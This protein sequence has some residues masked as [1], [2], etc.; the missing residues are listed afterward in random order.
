MSF[1]ISR[2]LS[3]DVI[4]KFTVSACLSFQSHFKVVLLAACSFRSTLIDHWNHSFR[5]STPLSHL[6][7]SL[8]VLTHLRLPPLPQKK[9]KIINNGNDQSRAV[10]CGVQKRV[11]NWVHIWNV[12]KRIQFPSF[13]L[14]LSSIRQIIR[15][16]SFQQKKKKPRLKFEPSLHKSAGFEQL[17]PELKMSNILLLPKVTM[18][19]KSATFIWF[20]LYE[21][22]QIQPKYNFRRKKEGM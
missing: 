17:G 11:G 16:N 21:E 18:L 22:F 13:C 15:E 14:Q 10:K 5:T 3:R 9:K 8:I 7:T 2:W 20:Y 4:T 6:W 12:K 1:R 19:M